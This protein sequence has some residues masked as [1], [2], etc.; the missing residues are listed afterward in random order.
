MPLLKKGADSS[1]TIFLS[2]PV[3]SAVPGIGASEVGEV[4]RCLER[5]G[6]THI[7]CFSHCQF[8]DSQSRQVSSFLHECM[9]EGIENKMRLD[10]PLYAR[11]EGS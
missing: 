10:L 11:Q 8:F 5:L 7:R 4:D 3:L 2:G 9:M 1:S 6:T